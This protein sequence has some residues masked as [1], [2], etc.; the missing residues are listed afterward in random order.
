MSKTK[1]QAPHLPCPCSA[2]H[3][4]FRPCIYLVS[5]PQDFHF[6]CLVCC[7]TRL[8]LGALQVYSLLGSCPHLG[9][10]RGLLG[11]DGPRLC[12][13]YDINSV[14]DAFPHTRKPPWQL[15]QGTTYHGGTRKRHQLWG[16]AFLET[17]RSNP[18]TFPAIP[19]SHFP[20]GLFFFNQ[21]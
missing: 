10:R 3:S 2:A 8:V 1:A 16:S 18:S 15:P 17:L 6:A 5:D 7:W 13:P 4:L 12:L 19:H 20:L 14:S 11:A 9:L 21:S